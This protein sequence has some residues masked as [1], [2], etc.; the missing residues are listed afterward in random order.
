MSSPTLSKPQGV[1]HPKYIF[2]ALMFALAAWVLAF[3][4]AELDATQNYALVLVLLIVPLWSTG[5]VPEF[6]TA[7]IF[8]LIAILAGIAEPNVVFSG[9]AS[10]ALWLIFAGTVMGMGIQ[11][12][13]LGDR[14]A[15][16]LQ[17]VLAGSYERLI[18]GLVVGGLLLGFV[19]PSSMGR[20]VMMLPIVLA[21]SER[22]G[23]QPGTM[24]RSGIIM[25]LAIGT[26]IP[27]VAILPANIPN[28]VLSGAADSLYGIQF[29]YLDY[30]ILH[31]PVLGALKAALLIAIILWVYPARE[32]NAILAKLNGGADVGTM[33]A[34]AVKGFSNGQTRML[35]VLLA[36]LALW[37]TD[38]W[39]GMNPAWVGLAAAV[40]MMMPGVNL[41]DPKKL[42]VNAT[43][44]IFIAG[45]L[46]IGAVI[47]NSG[48]GQWFAQ[49]LEHLFPMAPGDH[50]RNYLSLASMSFL[51]TLPT[52]QAGA[53]AM[54]A[55]MAAHFAETSG[56][57]LSTVLMTQVLGYSSI[58]FPYQSGPL[59]MAMHLSGEPASRVLKVQFPLALIT[60]LV[61]VPL[62][63]LWWDWLGMFD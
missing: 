48:L 17:R 43:M 23:F 62:D 33:A 1:F 32:S 16:V 44:L 42:N 52:T 4:V 56:F 39:H 19:M 20:L 8:F 28:M 24:G 12:T 34:T 27:T 63:Y 29:G 37:L 38:S 5:A 47:N 45:I 11:N 10:T 41:V 30:L 3:P 22:I 54:L 58:M 21:L 46:G 60:L 53:P 55:P 61:L 57:A 15:S 31:F 18:I 6:L 36:A 49:Q 50:F 59:L 25:A 51:A 40:L 13:G 2:L 26:H 7:L 35:L 9:F 14:L